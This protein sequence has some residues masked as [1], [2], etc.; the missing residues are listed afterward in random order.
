MKSCSGPSNILGFNGCDA[1]KNK[2]DDQKDKSFCVTECPDA[3]YDDND[4]CKGKYSCAAK[5]MH[6][7]YQSLTIRK[8]PLIHRG[9]T[10]Y[11]QDVR[12]LFCKKKCP[13]TPP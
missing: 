1:C 3:K 11:G 2:K 12:I 10:L 13:N 6:Q 5:S 8:L 7:Y 9:L 4:H